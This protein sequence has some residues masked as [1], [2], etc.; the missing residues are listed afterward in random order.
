MNVSYKHNEWNTPYD[1]RKFTGAIHQRS[2]FDKQK[3]K[4]KKE[5]RHFFRNI[6]V[7]HP[8]FVTET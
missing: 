7:T 1:V 8:L 4:K 2:T 5:R 6:S 3:K